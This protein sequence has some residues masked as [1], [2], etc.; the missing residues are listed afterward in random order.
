[1]NAINLTSN[2]AA[3]N[4]AKA[5]GESAEYLKKLTETKVEEQVT[6]EKQLE[7]R[8][9]S[10]FGTGNVRVVSRSDFEALLEQMKLEFEN[11]NVSVNKSKLETALAVALQ[12]MNATSAAQKQALEV[13]TQRQVEVNTCTEAYGTAQ[14]NLTNAQEELQRLK[15]D[16]KATEEQIAAQ[17]LVVTAMQS[18]LDTAKTNLDTANANLAAAFKALDGTSVHILAVAMTIDNENLDGYL[19][20]LQRLKEENLLGAD[21]IDCLCMALNEVDP[22]EINRARQEGYV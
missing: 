18:A 2:E 5:I 9:A 3:L 11:A 13:C 15:D 12:Y 1:M 4:T 17:E 19:A 8:L 21:E 7:G 16:K 22:E 10:L 6:A 20:Q 14:T